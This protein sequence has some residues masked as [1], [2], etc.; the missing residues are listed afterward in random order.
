MNKSPMREGD[1]DVHFVRLG[2]IS[3]KF[4]PNFSDCYLAVN[5]IRTSTFQHCVLHR[6]I[7]YGNQKLR[8]ARKILKIFVSIRGGS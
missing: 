2:F 1:I 6:Q 4:R 5:S 7:L 3:E 8:A